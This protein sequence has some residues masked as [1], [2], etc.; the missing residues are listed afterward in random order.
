MSLQGDKIKQRQ[1]NGCTTNYID[2]CDHC[3]VRAKNCAWSSMFGQEDVTKKH[4]L[5]CK[6]TPHF[7]STLLDCRPSD[8][9]NVDMYDTGREREGFSKGS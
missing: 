6:C 2:L 4:Q 9:S 1:A 7:A 8:L 3:S 5:L